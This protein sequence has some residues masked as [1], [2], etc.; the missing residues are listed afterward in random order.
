MAY[1]HYMKSINEPAAVMD[2]NST[3]ELSLSKSSSNESLILE[4]DG[5]PEI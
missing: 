1:E 5:G 3:K 4:E 2:F